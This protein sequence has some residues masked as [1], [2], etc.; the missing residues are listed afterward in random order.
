MLS[1]GRTGCG[2]KYPCHFNCTPSI[3]FGNVHGKSRITLR[4]VPQI[5][6]TKPSFYRT[7]LAPLI[8]LEKLLLIM[9]LQNN[10]TNSPTTFCT[11]CCFWIVIKAPLSTYSNLS[12]VMNHYYHSVQVYWMKAVLAII[13]TWCFSRSRKCNRTIQLWI[14]YFREN[15]T[16]H[17]RKSAIIYSRIITRSRLQLLRFR[18]RTALF[19][20][21]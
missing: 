21:I 14:S 9:R 4:L 7:K 1:Q 20:D 17:F 12:E 8:A 10:Y 3:P 5:V 13:S 2:P 16:L 6:G 19:A 15:V 11:N 18:Q